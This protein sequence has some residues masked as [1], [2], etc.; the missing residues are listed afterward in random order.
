MNTTAI[1][2]TIVIVLLVLY[3]LYSAYKTISKDGINGIK[4]MLTKKL[5]MLAVVAVGVGVF[6]LIY[7]DVELQSPHHFVAEY[8]SK[9]TEE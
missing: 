6:V 3:K 7:P 4:G 9:V 2:V 1:I 5:M 8:I